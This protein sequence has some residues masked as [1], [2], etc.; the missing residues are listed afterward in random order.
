MSEY[1]RQNYIDGDLQLAVFEHKATHFQPKYDGIWC[2]C[3]ITPVDET[4]VVAQYY[5]RSN[6]LKHS[7]ILPNSM[8]LI[9]TVTLVGE[10]MFGTER[11]QDEQLYEKLFVFDVW[12]YNDKPYL[13]RWQL[14]NQIVERFAVDS[15]VLVPTLPV[16]AFANFWRDQVVNNDTYEGVVFRSLNSTWDEPLIRQKHIVTTDFRV[17][18]FVEGQ[19]KYAGSLGALR[20]VLSLDDTKETTIGGGLTDEERH[21]IWQNQDSYLGRTCE[22]EGSGQFKSGLLRHPRFVRWHNEK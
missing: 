21:E 12:G 2:A 13:E 11:A 7:A 14:A 20:A 10:F 3:E 17:V 22:V 18:G 16:S 1:Q 6:Q 4:T 9:T 15:F 19:G 8:K 5:S